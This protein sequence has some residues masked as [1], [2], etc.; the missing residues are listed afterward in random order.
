MKVSNP[1]LNSL[2]FQD[3]N[4]RIVSYATGTINSQRDTKKGQKGHN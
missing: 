2:I 1:T 4:L 3:K